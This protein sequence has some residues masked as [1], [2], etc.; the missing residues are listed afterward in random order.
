MVMQSPDS[1]MRDGQV[2]VMQSPDIFMRDGT[3]MK[4]DHSKFFLLPGLK[5]TDFFLFRLDMSTS[6]WVEIKDIGNRVLFSGS[7]SSQSFSAAEL[8][9]KENQIFFIH[10]APIEDLDTWKVFDMEEGSTR[11]IE[12]G[13]SASDPFLQYGCQYQCTPIWVIPNFGQ[14]IKQGV[15]AKL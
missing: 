7:N 6:S 1:F 14:D 12:Y 15:F 8:G 4:S 11:R 10:Q 9:C 3:E 13:L 2:M 5:S